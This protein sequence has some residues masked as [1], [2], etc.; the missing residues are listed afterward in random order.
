[1]VSIKH[2]PHVSHSAEIIS[3][4]SQIIARQISGI[5]CVPDECEGDIDILWDFG[6]WNN[7][8]DESGKGPGL[9]EPISPRTR[10]TIM[11]DEMNGHHVVDSYSPGSAMT[12]VSEEPTYLALDDQQAFSRPLSTLRPKA[13]TVISLSSDSTLNESPTST[14]P[15]SKV[16]ADIEQFTLAYEAGRSKL[17]P[18]RKDGKFTIKIL[19]ETLSPPVRYS[20]RLE[21]KRLKEKISPSRPQ[22]VKKTERSPTPKSRSHKNTTIVKNVRQQ[23]GK[24]GRCVK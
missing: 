17:I 9:E 10:P 24:G 23:H 14:S 7:V 8:F 5:P 20:K 13:P 2:N 4:E 11:G 18:T 6:N 16:C 19:R 21:S 3:E 15:A 22:G 1:M 12:V